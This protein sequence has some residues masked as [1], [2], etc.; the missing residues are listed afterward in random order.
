MHTPMP[1]VAAVVD[2]PPDA[3]ARIRG[4]QAVQVAPAADDVVAPFELPDLASIDAV[5]GEV[6]V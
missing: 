2:E 1:A 3:R 5:R 4:R 6:V